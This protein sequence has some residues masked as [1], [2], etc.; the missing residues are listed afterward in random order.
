MIF[1]GDGTFITSDTHY[2]HEN[3]C[4]ATTN[5]IQEKIADEHSGIREFKSLSQ[6]NDMI[7][8]NING[9]VGVE[10][11]LIHLGDWS[12]GGIENIFKFRK[13]I[14]CKNVYLILG[15]HDHHIEKDSRIP[16]HQ[17][18]EAF[19]YITNYLDN[20]DLIIDNHAACL[21]DL[22]T[23]VSHVKQIKVQFNKSQKAIPIFLSHYSHRV[24]NKHH[25][26]YF[27][28]FGHS[29]NSLNRLPN[30][31]S[32]DVGIDCAFHKFG[33]YRPFTMREFITICKKQDIH[34]IDHH[35]KNTN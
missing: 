32:M 31:R 29:H 26:G 14:N 18:K 7:V 17:Q 25:K 34:Q 16:E 20:P 5:W 22:F 12:F 2:G 33:E 1:N 19:D 11:N 8:N 10:D 24:W 3:I 4:S 9:T 28:A 35:N 15:N 13:R 6:M 30:G 27:H 21:Q 23:S